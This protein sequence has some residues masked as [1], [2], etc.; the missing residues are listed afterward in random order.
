M[1]QSIYNELQLYCRTINIIVK[2]N[3]SKPL[4]AFQPTPQ[5][6]QAENQVA[7][8]II[9]AVEVGLPEAS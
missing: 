5:L 2:V 8:I 4:P 9:V 7:Y 1:Q 3:H 6:S